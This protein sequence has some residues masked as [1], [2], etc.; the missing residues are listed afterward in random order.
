MNIDRFSGAFIALVGL[1]LLYVL[2]PLGVEDIYAI[3]LTPKTFP[4]CL[5]WLLVIAGCLQ[6]IL[7]NKST[8]VIPRGLSRVAFLCGV[9]GVTIY[10]ATLT[11]FILI[12]PFLALILMY[13]MNERR[14]VWLAIGV[15][16]AP[17]VIWLVV[18]VLLGRELI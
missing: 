1:M 17:L 14:P 10:I 9:L 8:I 5:S 7:S 12:A 15:V 4:V 3:G 11:R 13:F 18:G 2:I 6:C 16:I